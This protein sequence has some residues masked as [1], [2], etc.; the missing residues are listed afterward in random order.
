MKITRKQL[1][2]ILIEASTEDPTHAKLMTLIKTGDPEYIK[3]SSVLAEAIG[4]N[5]ESFITQMISS[6]N[7]FESIAVDNILYQIDDILFNTREEA[8]KIINI[9][10]PLTADLGLDE[11]AIIDIDMELSFGVKSQAKLALEKS[12]VQLIIA[13]AKS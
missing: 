13:I 4:I 8:L 7:L 6:M 10:D 1:R 11:D 3:Q 9:P 2:K 5:F 12:I